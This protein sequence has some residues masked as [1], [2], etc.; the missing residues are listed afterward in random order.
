[1]LFLHKMTNFSF[2]YFKKIDSTNAFMAGVPEKERIGAVVFAREQ[3]AGKGMGANSWGSQEGENLTFSMGV[4]MSFLQAANQF[5]LSQAVPLGLLDVLDVML[6]S[7]K[8]TVKWPNDIF[9][10]DRKLCGILINST[11]HGMEMGVSVVGIGLNVNQMQFQEWP[12]HPVSMRMILGEEV[13]LEPLM[14]QLV[15]AV[16]RRVQLLR[17]DEGI[18]VI[19]QDYLNRLYRFRTWSDFEVNGQK[20]RRFIT[21]IDTFGRLETLDEEG[22]KYV[23][24]IKEIKFV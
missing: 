13:A 5:L 9:F 20:L 11:I 7:S 6:P 16:D 1:M 3:T 21:G 2:T 12:T 14:K 24:D 23:Y 8:L 10:E 17:T 18:A 19:R 15:D 22:D 4:D